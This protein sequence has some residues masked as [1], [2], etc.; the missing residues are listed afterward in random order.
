MM[1][2]KT[3]SL[4][5]SIE[6][7]VIVVIA[8]VVLGLG[9]GFVKGTFKD[10]TST[11]GDVQASIKEQ[12]LN[13][14]RTSN[15]K[16]S[17]P[18][19]VILERGEESVQGIGVMNTGTK[20]M[21]YGLKIMPIKKLT[22]DGETVADVNVIN[23]EITFFYSDLIDQSLAPTDANVIK[24]TISVSSKASGNYLYNAIVLSELTPNG[25]S[26]GQAVEGQCRVY[27]TQSFFVKVA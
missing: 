17:V 2:N 3:G 16:L 18:G 1:K 10:L 19:Q 24:V 7:I 22:P 13:D 20:T 23:S 25:C 14:M 6:A 26:S 27:D 21:K 12:I 8:F 9:L 11:S 15:K 4:S 5:L